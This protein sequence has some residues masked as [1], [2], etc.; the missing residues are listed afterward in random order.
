MTVISIIKRLIILSSIFSSG[1]NA[2]IYMAL[3]PAQIKIATPT[4]DSNPLLVD[5]RLGY[6]YQSHQ[7]ELVSMNS[8]QANNINQLIIDVPTVQAIFYRYSSIPQ[9]R[10]VSY[11]IIGASRLD[12]TAQYPNVIKTTE[13]YHGVSVGIGFEEAFQSIPQ[14]KMKLDWIRLYSGDQLNIDAVNLGLRYA[15]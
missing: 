5:V 2:G 3:A 13:T 9:A 8:L 10:I 7:L 15:F 4:T 12:I 11:L 14:L 1:V 6:T